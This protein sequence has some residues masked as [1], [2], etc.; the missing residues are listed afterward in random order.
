V[1]RKEDLG[2]MEQRRFREILEKLHRELHD[3]TSVDEKTKQ[4]LQEVESD[5]QYILH[6]SE[7]G[8]TRAHHTLNDRLKQAVGSL[9]TTNPDLT[10]TMRRVMN[11]LSNMGI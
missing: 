1:N 6:E 8:E 9:E 4:L 3:T 5:I 11:T 10:E 2:F 7:G